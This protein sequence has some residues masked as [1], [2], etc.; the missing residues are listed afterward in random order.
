MKYI[1]PAYI[2]GKYEDVTITDEDLKNYPRKY[3]PYTMYCPGDDITI[4][5]ATEILIT[6]RG[7]VEINRKII[8]FVYGPPKSDDMFSNEEYIE[9]VLKD[10]Q[11]NGTIDTCQTLMLETSI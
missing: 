2:N 9:R 3:E 5:W 6:P 1:A 10:Y 11:D 4:I 8:N 7:N